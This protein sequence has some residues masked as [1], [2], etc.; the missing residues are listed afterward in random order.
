MR[1]FFI[2][3]KILCLVPWCLNKRQS[4]FSV[5]GKEYTQLRAT[6]SLPPRSHAQTLV[7]TLSSFVGLLPIGLT[8]ELVS[9]FA[10]R[11]Q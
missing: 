7:L 10:I 9:L 4:V 3:V 8:V 1:N 2:L 11:L 6:L 5:F